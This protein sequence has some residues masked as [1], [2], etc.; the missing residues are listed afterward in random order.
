[1]TRTEWGTKYSDS[2]LIVKQP[3]EAEAR[4]VA[5]A[6]NA[7]DKSTWGQSFDLIVVWRVVTD[8]EAT[9]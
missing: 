8:W 9:S 7:I 3:S 4:R 6:H 1:M 2:G 5:A